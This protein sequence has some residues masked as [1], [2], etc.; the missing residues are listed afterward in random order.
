MQCQL[1]VVGHRQPRENHGLPTSPIPPPCK[2]ID[3]VLSI[4]RDLFFLL[5]LLLLLR[6]MKLKNN[7]SVLCLL[8]LA[9]PCVRKVIMYAQRGQV[10]S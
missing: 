9:W 6:G 7:K 1:A 5:L 4:H 8:D 2:A 10:D 3:S